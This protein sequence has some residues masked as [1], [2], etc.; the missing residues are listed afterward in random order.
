MWKDICVQ[1]HNKH[2]ET[3]QMGW[4][5]GCSVH[6]AAVVTEHL[7]FLTQMLR[8]D[9]TL[10]R[11]IQTIW[12]FQWTLFVGVDHDVTLDAFLS[13]V[14]P[15][16][17]AHPLAFTLGALVLAKTTLLPLVRGQ[18]FALRP[19]LRAVLDVVSFVEA[20]VTQVGGRR[21][22]AG[23]AVNRKTE[24]GEM[25]RQVLDAAE[26]GGAQGLA[27]ALKGV[28]RNVAERGG[29]SPGLSQQVLVFQQVVDV[30][31]RCARPS[32]GLPRGPQVIGAVAS[33]ALSVDGVVQV[34]E[35]AVGVGVRV[36]MCWGCPDVLLISQ[37]QVH[38]VQQLCRLVHRRARV[39]IGQRR[40]VD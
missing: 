6:T 26:R 32:R 2:Q 15:A 17:A 35:V 23:F 9:F 28:R 22:F 1:H 7:A 27:V 34:V 8:V 36:G 12:L 31:Q 37:R 4:M 19:S 11:D 14:G 39:Q 3:R 25:V 20:Q 33:W 16:V 10:V 24:V 29:V 18:T 21:P 5:K 38:P 13:H 40:H 30:V